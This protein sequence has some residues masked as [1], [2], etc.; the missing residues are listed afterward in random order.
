MDRDGSRRNS[1]A[2]GISSSFKSPRFNRNRDDER[3]PIYHSNDEQENVLLY[4]DN[5]NIFESAREHSSMTKGYHST[6][7]DKACRIDIGKLLTKALGNRVLLSGKLYG[8]EPPAVDSG[9]EI[10]IITKRFK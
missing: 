1:R 3:P 6:I 7:I 10:Y 8:S 9:I 5:S 4:I 2:S